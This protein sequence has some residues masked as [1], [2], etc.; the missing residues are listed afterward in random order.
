[1]K[2]PDNIRELA[3]LSPDMMG[4]IFYPG[5]K[6]FVGEDFAIPEISTEIKRVGVFVNADE[7]YIL[8]KVKQHGLDF[9]QLH[10]EETPEFCK[11]IAKDVKVIKA[12][13]IDE[14]FDFSV[15]AE[16]ENSC[17]YFLFDTKTDKYGGSGKSFDWSV[18]THYKGSKRFFLSGG[19]G[20]DQVS[21]L[22]S[23]VPGPY[24]V[25]VNSKF[26]TE[27][28]IKDINKLKKLKDELSGKR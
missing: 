22:S 16:Y 13:G 11:T 25:D 23:C 26:E 27:P 18:L 7:N 20:L 19:I 12:F 2:E 15:L 17:D 3:K 9:V 5:S 4:F 28:G 24:A 10:G 21:G 14:H 8:Q 6:R 1:M